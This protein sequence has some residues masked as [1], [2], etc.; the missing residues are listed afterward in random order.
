MMN[1]SR[2]AFWMR[3]ACL[4]LC[5]TA[6]GKAG[7]APAATTLVINELLPPGHAFNREVLEPWGKAV[8][9]VTQG[10]VHVSIP[11]VP[12]APPAQLWNAVVE[13]VVDGAY[14]FN[15]LIPHQLPLE[16]IAA[17]PF[18]GGTSES[19]SVALWKT[20]ERYFKP[21]HEYRSV[22]LL[23]L[24]S[25]PPDEIYS[26]GR[27]IVK[28]GDL[29]GRRL[30]ALP[31]VPQQLLAKSGAGVVSSPAVQVSELVAG[32]T[33]DSVAGMDDY[34]ARAFKILGYMKSETVIPGGL[35][36]PSFSLIVNRR[37][38]ESIAPADRAAIE[39]ISGLAFARRMQRIN[40][41]NAAAR[42]YSEKLGIRLMQASPALMAE[43]K[44]YAKP[45]FTQWLASARA[46]H[47]DG[48]AALKY[49]E[50]QAQAH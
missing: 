19:S 2:N 29:K 25:L 9:R 17:L 28:P 8:E 21:A 49:F 39:R 32:G 18:I 23:A 24:F 20:Y 45:L 43:F 26:M 12:L 48:P 44:G 7:A 46:M 42:R 50:A 47:V 16:Q 14:V 33:V 37:K 6:I 1:R 31:G 4:V 34:D 40:V 41:A 38:W 30:W 13:D 5:V 36:M 35:S 22:K 15:G 11:A 27:P 3:V 10:R